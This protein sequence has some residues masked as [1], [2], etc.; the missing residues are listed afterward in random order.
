MEPICGV[1]RLMLSGTAS[2]MRR[3]PS[4]PQ[5]ICGVRELYF[6][7]LMRNCSVYHQKQRLTSQTVHMHI[8]QNPTLQLAVCTAF[9]G[10]RSLVLSRLAAQ[11]QH[12]P[13]QTL[14]RAGCQTVHMASVRSSTQPFCGVRSLVLSRVAA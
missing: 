2:Q 13:S 6:R 7:D 4:N 1:R 8:V 11:E 10:V 9:L 3:I 14:P 5:L 12:I